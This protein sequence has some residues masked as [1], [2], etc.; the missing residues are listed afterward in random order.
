MTA[1]PESIM[2][3]QFLIVALAGLFS[4]QALLAIPIRVLAWDQEIAGRKLAIVQGKGAVIL[5]AMHP[6]QRT[7]AYQASGGEIPLVIQALDKPLVEDKP[8]SSQILIP[9]ALKRP[10]L[11]LLPDP[12]SATGL[13][14]VLLEDDTSGFPWG[15]IRFIN[16][17]AKKLAFVHD[18]K[19]VA[20]PPSWDPVQVEPGG[21]SRN[22][23]VQFYFYDTPERSIYSSVWLFNPEVRTLVFLVPGEDPRLGPVA[24]KMIRE[25]R[26]LLAAVAAMAE[27]AKKPDAPAAP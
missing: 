25:D 7:A 3:S 23:D 27:A 8:A 11:L 16:A 10:L 24:M 17:C 14:L 18:K 13:R 2:Q 4:C 19:V 6:S 9:A 22:L 20:L 5:D 26:R 12:K 15:S 21:S 1:S